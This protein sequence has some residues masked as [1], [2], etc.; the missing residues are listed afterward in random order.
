MHKVVMCQRLLTMLH[1]Q[2]SVFTDDMHSLTDFV[3]TSHQHI[4]ASNTLSLSSTYKL[5]PYCTLGVCFV[6]L[7]QSKH[8]MQATSVL[9]V[10]SDEQCAVIVMFG[11]SG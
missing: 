10:G 2:H 11:T 1:V 9:R 7:R 4:H 3:L 5:L 6:P 8:D